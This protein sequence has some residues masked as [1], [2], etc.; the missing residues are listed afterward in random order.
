MKAGGAVSQKLFED[1]GVKTTGHRP[2]NA[3]RETFCFKKEA[4]VLGRNSLSEQVADYANIMLFFFS[5]LTQRCD[6]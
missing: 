6:S 4:N 2:K 1:K 3:F 5:R